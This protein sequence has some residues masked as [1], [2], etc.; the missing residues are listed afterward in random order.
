[1]EN[2]KCNPP[3]FIGSSNAFQTE[4]KGSFQTGLTNSN[5]YSNQKMNFTTMNASSSNFKKVH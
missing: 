4:N 5:I 2:F 3:Q 1:M